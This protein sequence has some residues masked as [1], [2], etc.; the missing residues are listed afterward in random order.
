MNGWFVTLGD[1]TDATAETLE[2]ANALLE[3]HWGLKGELSRLSGENIN[4]QLESPGQDGCV[5]KIIVN[6]HID[7]SLEAAVLEQLRLEGIPVPETIRS[8][9]GS[10]VVETMMGE[11]RSTARLQSFLAGEL[12]CDVKTTPELLRSIGITIGRIHQALAGLEEVHPGLSRT[13]TWDLA[14]AGQHRKRIPHLSSKEL[15]R[16]AEHSFFLHSS[17]AEP[18]LDACPR[19]VLHGDIN[20]ENVLV[21]KR[22][23]CRV[24][25]ILVTRR[26]E[27][28]FWISPSV[29]PTHYSMMGLAFK[30]PLNLFQA[31]NRYVHWNQWNV[32][33]LFSLLMARLATTVCIAAQRQ[34]E[35]QI[36]PPGF[37]MLRVPH[38]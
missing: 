8:R 36:I 38:R 31:T 37:H 35:L 16:A 34:V 21:Q 26:S 33:S 6:E 23:N 10:L 28:W 29:L 2:R 19:G 17:C 4:Y 12:W 20:D 30:R 18:N 9:D 13:H 25:L 1:V 14:R 11:V 27:R 15:R 32:V 3:A 22:C 24:E 7:L 5:L